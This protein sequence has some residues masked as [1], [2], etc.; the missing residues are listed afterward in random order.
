MVGAPFELAD[1]F[2]YIHFLSIAVAIE[3]RH[4]KASTL[5]RVVF[6]LHVFTAPQPIL[7]LSFV[8]DGHW[9]KFLGLQTGGSLWRILLSCGR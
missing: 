6:M 9:T 2:V 5:A 7:V 3:T 4:W 8:L 1:V